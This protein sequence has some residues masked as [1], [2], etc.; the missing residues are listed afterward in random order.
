M[1]PRQSQVQELSCLEQLEMVSGMPVSNR[2][3]RKPQMAR[4][5]P[6]WHF[7]L[8]PSAIDCWNS[9][10]VPVSGPNTKSVQRTQLLLVSLYSSVRSLPMIASYKTIHTASLALAKKIWEA[11]ILLHHSHHYPNVI[12]DFRRTLCPIMPPVPQHWWG[13]ASH[14]VPLQELPGFQ[15]NCM[16]HPLTLLALTCHSPWSWHSCQP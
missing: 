5:L 4:I 1:F 16:G 8:W 2:V 6:P 12:S 3:S 13:T 14:D 15:P 9:S 10:P 7:F 11:N